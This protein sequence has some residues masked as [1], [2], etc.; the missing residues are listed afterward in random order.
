[1]YLSWQI[2]QSG[3]I[4][5]ATSNNHRKSAIYFKS[6]KKVVSGLSSV[7]NVPTTAHRSERIDQRRITPKITR[8]GSITPEICRNHISRKLDAPRAKT[9]L[10]SAKNLTFVPSL[11][12]KK[13]GPDIAGI[14]T[15]TKINILILQKFAPFFPP[16]RHHPPSSPQQDKFLVPQR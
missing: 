8:K 2:G 11:F 7:N 16:S 5:V 14:F 15:K 12:V 6:A 13:N 4:N 3:S 10:V 1:M 9:P